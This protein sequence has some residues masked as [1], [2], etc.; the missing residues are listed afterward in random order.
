MLNQSHGVGQRVA[1]APRTVHRHSHDPIRILFIP[2]PRYII[3]HIR[4]NCRVARDAKFV[5]PRLFALILVASLEVAL[6][7][8][9]L[10]DEVVEP[11]SLFTEK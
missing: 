2:H 4:R 8:I 1:V 11:Q 3:P 7:L 6:V 10:T 5:V 9:F